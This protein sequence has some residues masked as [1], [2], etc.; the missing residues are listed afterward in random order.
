[1]EV[2]AQIQGKVN[3]FFAW[4]NYP[5]IQN[6]YIKDLQNWDAL[7]ASLHIL[8]DLQRP[9]NEYYSLE[10]VNYLEVIGIMQTLYIEQDSMQT[11]KNALL[12]NKM[13]VLN[14]K[15]MIR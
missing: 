5:I 4:I 10:T 6:Y 3:R 13:M 7:C 2:E 12:E 14:L 1:M 15:I 8:N 9:K 11:L